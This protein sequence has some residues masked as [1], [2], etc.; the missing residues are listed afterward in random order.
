MT[1]R[2]KTTGL[3]NVTRTGLTFSL[4]MGV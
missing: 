3:S 1:Q 4:Q 2:N